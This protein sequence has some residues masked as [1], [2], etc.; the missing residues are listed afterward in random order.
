MTNKLKSEYTFFMSANSNCNFSDNSH[1]LHNTPNLGLFRYSLIKWWLWKHPKCSEWLPRLTDTMSIYTSK[2]QRI[3][4]IQGQRTNHWIPTAICPPF[5]M[6]MKVGGQCLISC[7]VVFYVLNRSLSTLWF[8]L[9]L[10]KAREL[11]N[12]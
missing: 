3:Q 4:R 9:T 5:C 6:G 8:P 7:N 10:L 11:F 2:S 12:S 1:W